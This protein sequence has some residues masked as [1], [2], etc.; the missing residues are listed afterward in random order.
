[1]RFALPRYADVA[2]AT[3]TSPAEAGAELR[4]YAEVT[5]AMAE[6]GVLRGG[7]ALRPATEG[8]HLG[9]DAGEV[10]GPVHDDPE[11]S[12][13]YVV[14]CPSLA[15]A[16]RWARRLPVTAHGR[17]EVRPLMDLPDLDP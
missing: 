17:V 3:T 16:S 15:E 8:V 12:G 11:L 7:E 10:P 4:R 5:A 13:F 9:S 2:A 1:M 6:A 14:E